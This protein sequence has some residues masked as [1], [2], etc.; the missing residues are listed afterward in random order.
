MR[1]G[2]VGLLQESNTFITE[3][4]SR[5]H[6][7]E[8][9][10]L[11]GE[12]IRAA[13]AD[14]PHEVGGFFEELDRAGAEAVPI[15]LARALPYGAIQRADFEQLVDGMLEAVAAAGP[16][17]GLLAAPH[18]ATVAEGHPDADG[19][20]L[21]RLRTALGA[22]VPIVGTLDLHANLSPSMVAATDAMVAYRMNPH[23]DQRETG[24]RAARLLVSALEGKVKLVQAAV[25]PP[26]AINIRTQNTSEPPMRDFYEEAAGLVD[27][28]GILSHSILHGFPYADV[29]EMGSAVLVVADGDEALARKAAEAVAA[30]MW[31]RREDFEPRQLDAAAALALASERREGPVVLLDMGDNVGGGS[32]ANGTAIVREW[33]RRGAPGKLF[34]CLHDPAAV[35]A[36]VAAGE[37]GAFEGRL[38]DPAEP[39]EGRF[40]VRSLHDGVFRETQAR[41]GGFSVFDQ[42]RTALLELD[43][44]GLVAMAT[45]RRMAPFSLAQL[46]SCGVDPADFDLIVAKGVIAPMAAYAPVAKGGFLHV[47]TPGATRADMTKL[48]YR[49]RRRPMFPFERD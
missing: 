31:E 47:D 11:K 33:L 35:E 37:G 48:E 19:F 16:L 49:E 43:G 26:M 13:M 36:A 17:D 41:H 29:A 21:G 44:T 9:L 4:T 20:W 24:V 32:P 5:R 12:A 1:I 40:R 7:E 34:V 42:G 10:L 25:F 46:T 15:F 39:V 6:F 28:P 23:L 38:G 27:W 45:T 22:A 3:R 18:G 8:D 14:A 2:I 30:R